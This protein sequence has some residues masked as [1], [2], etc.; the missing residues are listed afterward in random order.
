MTPPTSP[1]PPPLPAPPH[2]HLHLHLHPPPNPLGAPPPPLGAPPPDV[3][4]VIAAQLGPGATVSRLAW[5]VVQVAPF[6]GRAY[7]LYV[8]HA[9]ARTSPDLIR[10]SVATRLADG[11]PVTCRVVRAGDGNGLADQNT[12]HAWPCQFDML[13]DAAEV[14]AAAAAKRSCDALLV[15]SRRRCHPV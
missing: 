5:D 14:T 3:L 6:P 2:P 1:A 13:V 12:F 10:A 15:C 11:A 7:T 8:P 4:A 9:T